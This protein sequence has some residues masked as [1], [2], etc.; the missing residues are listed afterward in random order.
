MRVT[1]RT[2]IDC[3]EIAAR[4]E[5]VLAE[6]GVPL[7]SEGVYFPGDE[8]PSIIPGDVLIF[9]TGK[10]QVKFTWQPGSDTTRIKGDILV[11]R[12]QKIINE[13]LRYR[14]STQPSLPVFGMGI[15]FDVIENIVLQHGNF[16]NTTA[17]T[18]DVIEAN[19][20]KTHKLTAD[21]LDIIH[22][23]VV[24]I[25]EETHNF[26]GKDRWIMHF[27]RQRGTDIE[28]E[29]GIDFR[30]HDWENKHGRDFRK[31]LKMSGVNKTNEDAFDCNIKMYDG[32]ESSVRRPV[33]TFVVT[34]NNPVDQTNQVHK[35]TYSETIALLAKETDWQWFELQ[36]M[37]SEELMNEYYKLERGRQ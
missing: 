10:K 13:K 2:L 31:S 9:T 1:K 7:Y 16:S 32:T 15:C 24:G 29:K 14:A 23:A 28:I 37:T 33:V 20:P 35:L 6:A 5:N 26:L 22:N 3:H 18:L 4:I 12:T 21:G 17:D 30:I 34:P 27:V 25:I 19:M 11:V 36:R 8:E